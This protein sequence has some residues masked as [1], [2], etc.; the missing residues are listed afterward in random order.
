[1]HTLEPL[2][3]LEQSTLLKELKFNEETTYAFIH[4]EDS[5][6]FDTDINN[7]YELIKDEGNNDD[8]DFICCPTISMARNWVFREYGVW[9]T[10]GANTIDWYL[11]S[12]PSHI[13]EFESNFYD[14]GLMSTT[15]IKSNN[16]H[17]CE[18]ECLT[19][20]LKHLKAQKH[21]TT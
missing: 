11:N 8:P 14:K 17:D 4:D 21:A 16:P 10:T 3:N 1:M 20:I 12:P 15:V 13:L 6:C 19:E 5:S 9:I 18:S 7:H 2:C